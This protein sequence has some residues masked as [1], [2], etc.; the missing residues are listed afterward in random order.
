MKTMGKMALSLLLAPV[1]A[2]VMSV[3]AHAYS[4]KTYFETEHYAVNEVILTDKEVLDENLK[5][6]I[7]KEVKAQ[8]KG[9]KYQTVTGIFPTGSKGLKGAVNQK[10]AGLLTI[11][12]Y[13]SGDDKVYFYERN[14][15]AASIGIT[16]NP[17]LLMQM[18]NNR[19]INPLLDELGQVPVI[20]ADMKLE[21]NSKDFRGTRF[22]TFKDRGYVVDAAIIDSLFYNEKERAAV[23]PGCR[24]TFMAM[25]D[26][27][28]SDFPLHMAVHGAVN[29]IT[30]PSD[31]SEVVLKA[32][33]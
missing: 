19:M 21:L 33:K 20:F 18:V 8:T 11:T 5:K 13:G 4:F 7:Q 2:A 32:S 10:L 9:T 25:P 15:Y 14:L 30:C 16:V 22:Y 31:K 24:V 27:V 6:R 28:T 3:S 17:D 1:A 23:K 12:N 29:S 26:R